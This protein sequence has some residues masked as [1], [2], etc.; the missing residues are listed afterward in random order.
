MKI[1][2]FV[3]GQT[4]Q[5]FITKLLYNFFP[6]EKI[7]ILSTRRNGRHE[8]INILDKASHAEYFV[9]IY[10]A[11]GDNRALSALKDYYPKMEHRGFTKFFV[12]RDLKSQEYKKFGDAIIDKQRSFI[13][14]IN[15]KKN[16]FL[17]Y[18][19]MEIEAWFLAAPQLFY[20]IDKRLTVQNI[21]KTI[22]QD[23]DVVDPEIAF[24]SP[25]SEVKRIFKSIDQSYSKSETDV[26]EIVSHIDWAELCFQ[27][28]GQ[29][30]SFFYDFL[31]D[32]SQII[33]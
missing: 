19:K 28:R 33:P 7:Q 25:A 18:S 17:H 2:I 21:K 22:G 12:L 16:I 13:N 30:I 26:K 27:F 31:D 8:E 9:L 5:I 14:Q 6:P 23:L 3:E 11:E 1:A 10:V 15:S 20:E 29:K 4:E 32:I 24:K